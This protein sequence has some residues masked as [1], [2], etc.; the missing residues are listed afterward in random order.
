MGILTEREDRFY[1]RVTNLAY[2]RAHE[3]YTTPSPSIRVHSS[4]TEIRIKSRFLS[5]YRRPLPYFNMLVVTKHTP[6]LPINAYRVSLSLTTRVHP[7][8][9]KKRRPIT[10]GASFVIELLIGW[11]LKFEGLLL[12]SWKRKAACLPNSACSCFAPC[13]LKLRLWLLWFRWYLT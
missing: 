9:W 12:L 11:R 2:L 10:I 8:Q 5:S 7:I 3:A 1:L 4:I 6:S 13:D